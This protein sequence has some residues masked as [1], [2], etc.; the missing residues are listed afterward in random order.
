[1]VPRRPSSPSRG[2][3]GASHRGG[4]HC[5][6]AA[7]RRDTGPALRGWR[8]PLALVVAL[9]ALLLPVSA[10][11]SVPGA[12]PAAKPAAQ[13]GQPGAPKEKPEPVWTG[14]PGTNLAHDTYGYPWPAAPDCDESNVGTG[15]CVNDGLGFFQG[16][17]TSWVAYRLGQ[18]N[19]LAFSNWFDGRHWGNA[20]EW[21]KVAKGLD[22]V[23][24]K[25][26]AVGAVGWYARGH[27]SYVEE[28][29]TDGSVVISE[30][31][32]DGH[33]GFVVHT[34]YPGETS[35]PDRFL[36]LADVVPVDLT[37]P[38]RPGAGHRDHRRRGRPGRLEGPRRRRRRHRLPGP[39][40]RDAAR[41]DRRADVRRPPGLARP[42]VHLLRRGPRR[43]RQRLAAGHDRARPGRAGTAE[44]AGSV[45]ARQRLGHRRRRQHRRLRPARQR[46]R[47]AGRL[48]AAHPRRLDDRPDRTLGA[49]GPRRHPRLRARRRRPGLVLP[50]AGREPR[51]PTPACPSTSPP[52]AGASTGSTGA[53]RSPP[54]P[55][56]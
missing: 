27:V 11:F 10:A 55:P 17:C 54:T 49:V 48:P 50:G 24:N 30:M 40:Q 23:S 1:M 44:A 21:S 20:S 46:A 51:R 32:T 13:P 36:H 45:P 12:P 19:G 31:N 39:A 38:D 41:R 29:N 34:V 53:T 25:V 2:V 33:N 4:N 18:R 26:P 56:G 16:Q 43:G 8:R 52:R 28:V 7:H 14:V 37:A 3:R 42:G 47:P 22:H 5:V 35:W 6:R 9:T 15:G